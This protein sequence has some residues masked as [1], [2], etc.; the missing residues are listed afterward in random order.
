MQLFA[1][2][3]FEAVEGV[4][5][6]RTS[7]GREGKEAPLATRLV[8]RV[9]YCGMCGAAA[10]LLPFFNGDISPHSPL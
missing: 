7:R 6:R 3:V 8:V 2:P 9:L 5:T 4:I 10:L 1:H